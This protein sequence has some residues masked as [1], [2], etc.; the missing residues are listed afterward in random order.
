MFIIYFLLFVAAV[1]FVGRVYKKANGYLPRWKYF[2]PYSLTWWTTL[3]PGVLGILISG[4]PLHGWADLTQSL[5]S[6]TGSI[7]PQILVATSAAGLGLTGKSV[8]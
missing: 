7:D 3:I 2:Q 1:I 5:V 4:E 8:D 6:V